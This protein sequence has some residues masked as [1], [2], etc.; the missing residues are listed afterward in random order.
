MKNF[1]KTDRTGQ[2][3]RP[4][5]LCIYNNSL[6]VYKRDSWGG[7]GSRG[8]FGQFITAEGVRS[9]KY[10]SVIF[11][12]DPLSS[13]KNQSEEIKLLCRKFYEGEEQ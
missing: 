4:G 1:R 10:T 8:E 9:V 12:F 7:E 3:I 13:R 5:D 11:A 6:V 2:E